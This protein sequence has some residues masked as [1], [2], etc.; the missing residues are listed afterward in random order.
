MI[1]GIHH[2]A[3]STK[4][5]TRALEFYCG[6][7]GFEEV[8]RFGWPKGY[9]D[10]DE[11]TGLNDSAATCVMLKKGNSFL[12]V[13]EFTAPPP[14][15]ALT[16]RPVCDHGITHICLYI[17]DM[18]SEYQRL[19]IAGMPFHSEPKTDGSTRMAYGRDPDGNVVELLEVINK[20][21]P[22]LMEV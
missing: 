15:E 21:D 7:L 17:S 2:P 16:E 18:D 5:M 8:K 12:E 20:E 9:A 14:Q 10:A 1:H 19:Q 22:A 4:D 13:F 3:I 6:V 11:L